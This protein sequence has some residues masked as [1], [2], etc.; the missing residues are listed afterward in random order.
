MEE[1]TIKI[2]IKTKGEKCEM[3]TEEIKRWYEEN[4]KK[5][6]NPEYGT[7]EICVEVERQEK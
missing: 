1:Q 2:T 6:F 5:L 4:V 3:T 7:P